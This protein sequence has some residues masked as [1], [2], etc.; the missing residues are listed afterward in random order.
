MATSGPYLSGI[1]AIAT[2]AVDLTG[3]AALRFVM[4]D[5]GLYTPDKAAHDSLADI[6]AGARVATGTL[7]GVTFSGG[8]MDA[9]DLVLGA[10]SGERT[11]SG[12][13]YQYHAT[14]ASAL[15]LFYIAN[16]PARPNGADIAIRW[17]N[18]TD[19]IVRFS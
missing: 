17:S 7:Y 9:D 5:E 1:D 3:A 19:K 12:V 16:L 4:V 10:V 13:I 11:E 2:G 6:P 14:E 18:G 15:L 8:V